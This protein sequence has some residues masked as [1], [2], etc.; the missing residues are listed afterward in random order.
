MKNYQKA[1]VHS[2]VDFVLFLSV[3]FT[4][5]LISAPLHNVNSIT[6]CHLVMVGKLLWRNN[7]RQGHI[8]L[9]YIL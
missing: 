6:W 3:H 8:L 1:V 2:N 7:T 5:V 4:T 9:T